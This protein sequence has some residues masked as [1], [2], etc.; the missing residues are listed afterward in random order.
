MGVPT[1]AKRGSVL[2]GRPEMSLRLLTLAPQVDERDGVL[3]ART[4]ILIR[5]LSLGMVHREVVVD[6]RARYV[7][8][9]ARWC[10]LIKRKRVIPFRQIHRIEYDYERT[11][12][13]LRRGYATVQTGD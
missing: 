12:T 4:P 10:W 11:A 13:S 5:L 1:E 8:I 9:D 6:R 3:R 7:T 2:A